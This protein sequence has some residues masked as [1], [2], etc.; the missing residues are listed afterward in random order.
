MPCSKARFV[1]AFQ[2]LSK[3]AR[4]ATRHGDS[5]DLTHAQIGRDL[6]DL[7]AA[8]GDPGRNRCIP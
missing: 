6:D 5:I 3:H 2:L 7:R 8:V 1:R 4:I